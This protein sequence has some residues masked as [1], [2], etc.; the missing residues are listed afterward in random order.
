MILT[1]SKALSFLA[2]LFLYPAQSYAQGIDSVTQMATAIYTA[3][4]YLIIAVG[5]VVGF[6]TTIAGVTHFKNSAHNRMQYPV[7]EG[8][9]KL[10]AGVGMLAFTFVYTV[11]KASFLTAGDTSW[12]ASGGNDVLSISNV[13]MESADA[14]ENS[15]IDKFLTNEFKAIIFG[16]LWL[17]GLIFLFVGIFSLKDVTSKKDGAI[18]GPLI[19]IAGAMV[20]MNP[21]LFLC[22]IAMLGPRFLCVE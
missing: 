3:P 17:T 19:R 11:L 21:M 10:G 15:F 7:A 5:L 13:V 20:C 18:K 4:G 1:K 6:A 8:I 12:A 2:L 14:T 9:A 22:V 16:L